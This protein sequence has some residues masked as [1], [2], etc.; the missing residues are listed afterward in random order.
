MP[1]SS[2]PPRNS[3]DA[4][5][6]VDT[7]VM[8]VHQAQGFDGLG[9]GA[10]AD[11]AGHSGRVGDGLGDDAGA[12]AEARHFEDA[13][14]AVPDDGAALLQ[15]VGELTGGRRG[16]VHDDATVGDA[17]CRRHLYLGRIGGELAGHDDLRG[18]V[19]LDSS[20]V[21]G[22]QH[23][24]GEL[25]PVLLH[26]GSADVVA[27]G[28]EEGDAHAAADEQVVQLV[29]HV[30][31]DQDLVADLGPAHQRSQGLFGG[32]EGAAHGAYFLLDEDAHGGGQVAGDSHG[33]G[34]GPMG[35]GEGVHHE[36]V[37]E[38]GEGLGEDG[39]I[40]L[41][42]GVEAQVLQQNDIA[43]AHGGD[44]SLHAGA[45][46]LRQA[47]HGVVQQEGQAVA[48]GGQAECLVDP[49]ARA[50]EM[51]AEDGA[52]AL[53]DEVPDG[54]QGGTQALVVSGDGLD[55]LL[56]GNV[57]VHSDKYPAARYVQLRQAALN[58]LCHSS[59]IAVYVVSR[60]WLSATSGS[61]SG[62]I[63]PTR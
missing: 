21:G 43:S 15:G 56:D 31:K 39:V 38:R 57:E 49:A 10:A 33:G 9:G 45:G 3:R 50:A 17:V 5:P 2:M 34:M 46:Y 14:G 23:L 27:L 52:A 18:Q 20:L 4:P 36:V 47:L 37:G 35:H 25:Q 55:P 13:H 51:G 30:L 53:V 54:G 12:L 16:D 1:G 59:A 22:V 40:G 11:H 41:L 28:L 60:G 24:A 42:A 6:P 7:W 48:D 61:R 63:G 8:A 44:C 19:D 29:H 26:L 62:P 32:L 58:H